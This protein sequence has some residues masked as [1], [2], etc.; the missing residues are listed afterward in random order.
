MRREFDGPRREPA[1]RGGAGDPAKPHAEAED[2]E[3]QREEPAANVGALA[4]DALV[5][6]GALVVVSIVAFHFYLNQFFGLSRNL[7]LESRTVPGVQTSTQPRSENQTRPA[8]ANSNPNLRPP[9]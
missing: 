7:S 8:V 6:A 3:D 4:K 1:R 9:T 2:R 5:V